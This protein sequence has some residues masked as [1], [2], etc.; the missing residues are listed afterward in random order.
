MIDHILGTRTL[1]VLQYLRLCCCCVHTGK[2]VCDQVIDRKRTSQV[3]DIVHS[4]DK[5]WQISL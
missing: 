2:H 5:S 4:P 3:Y 1:L